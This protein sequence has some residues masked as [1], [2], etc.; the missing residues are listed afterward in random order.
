[1][2]IS[3]SPREIKTLRIIVRRTE[4]PVSPKITGGETEVYRGC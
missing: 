2:T 1:M 4:I 3:I